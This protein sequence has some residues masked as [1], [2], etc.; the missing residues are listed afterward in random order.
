[1][2]RCLSVCASPLLGREMR[3]IWIGWKTSHA[4]FYLTVVTCLAG[5]QGALSRWPDASEFTW[6]AHMASTCFAGIWPTARNSHGLYTTASSICNCVQIIASL[7]LHVLLA[8]LLD[9]ALA[10]CRLIL[11]TDPQTVANRVQMRGADDGIGDQPS[12]EV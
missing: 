3:W 4:R 11:E 1:M 2:V 6:T 8:Q 12:L 7:L 9:G 5:S 10:V